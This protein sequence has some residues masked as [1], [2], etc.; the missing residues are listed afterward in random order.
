MRTFVKLIFF[1]LPLV[2][3]SPMVH[4]GQE[5]YVSIDI[6]PDA[7]V[8]AREYLLKDI[9]R[10][11]AQGMIK[12]ELENFSMGFSPA[13]G[14]VKRVSGERIAS[15]LRSI[16]WLPRTANIRFPDFLFI[17]RVGQEVLEETLRELYG[18]HIRES[19][20]EQEFEIRD[21]KIRGLDRYPMGKMEFSVRSRGRGKTKGRVRLEVDVTV[22][23]ISHGRVSVS[24]WVDI[25]DLV[26]CA[27]RSLSRGEILQQGDLC[28]RRLNV[29]KMPDNY[30]TNIHRAPGMRLKQNIRSGGFL[31]DTMLEK[32]PLVRRGESVTLVAIKGEMR[33]VATGIATRDGGLG[34]QIMV[35]NLSTGR[36]VSGRISGPKTVDVFF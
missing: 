28:L 25:Y 14:K 7:R 3:S 22:D 17:K 10:V 27:A 9:A 6:N 1:V 33:I 5:S 18:D 19:L 31:R 35:K 8:N 32:P 34:D 21:F 36:I 2:L 26:A 30:L 15:K 13:I 11:R 16:P 24:G 20:G 29:S 4:G 12:E 23:K